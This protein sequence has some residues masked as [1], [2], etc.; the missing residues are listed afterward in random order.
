M[1]NIDI[2]RLRQTQGLLYKH[3]CNYP[4]TPLGYLQGKTTGGWGSVLL[5]PAD[6]ED[7]DP[8]TP[9]GHLQGKTTGGWG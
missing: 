1:L 3:Q 2:D 5:R 6:K 4:D 8:D 9:L 7:Q